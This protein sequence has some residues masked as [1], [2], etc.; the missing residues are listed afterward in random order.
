M[1][2]LLLL[3]LLPLPL[4]LPLPIPLPLHELILL[5]PTSIPPL[6]A[7]KEDEGHKRQANLRDSSH[8][9]RHSKIKRTEE[10]KEKKRNELARP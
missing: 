9:Y 7:N 1:P 4:P 5:F 6:L 2:L 8:Y 10:R 3:L